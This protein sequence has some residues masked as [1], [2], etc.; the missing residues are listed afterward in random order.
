MLSLDI[1]SGLSVDGGTSPMMWTPQCRV[2]ILTFTPVIRFVT[3]PMM[4]DYSGT[5]GTDQFMLFPFKIKR[6][7]HLFILYLYM[8]FNRWLVSI[9]QVFLLLGEWEFVV[10]VGGWAPSA[11]GPQRSWKRPCRLE[12]LVIRDI[13]ESV[14]SL[15][16]NWTSSLSI[17]DSEVV[18]QPQTNR[19]RPFLEKPSLPNVFFHGFYSL[20]QSK[21]KKKKKKA[22][23]LPLVWIQLWTVECLLVWNNILNSEK[24]L[25]KCPMIYLISTLNEK[26]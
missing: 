8:S 5:P 6:L 11:W 25:D 23:H 7:E 16:P 17:F 9:V 10:L 1:S 19:C 4:A 3:L 24:W 21:L 14:S 18:K 20:N 15:I 2:F 12:S 26:D 13:L 22:V